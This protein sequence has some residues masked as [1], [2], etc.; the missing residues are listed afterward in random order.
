MGYLENQFYP[1]V[2]QALADQL[3]KAGYRIL[4]FTAP[5]GAADPVLEDVLRY[6]AEAVVLASAHLS[7]ALVEEC[8]I[9]RVP[10]VLINRK[11][12]NAA[13]SSVT[14][15]NIRGARAIAAFL[16]AGGHRRV[17]YMA[18]LEDASTS[19]DRERGFFGY[20]ADCQM[21]PPA[22]AVGSY[23]FEGAMAAARDLLTRD[24]RPDAIF[25]A[26][27]HMAL[28]ALEVARHEFNLAIPRDISIVGFDDAEPARWPSF[29]L[30]TYSQ[31][32]KPMVEE[33]VRILLRLIGDP[34]AGRAN[35]VVPGELIVRGSA[36]RPAAGITR[37]DG[38][39][40]WKEA[41]WNSQGGPLRQAPV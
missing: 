8:R 10:V 14:G 24:P 23:S 28:A 38:R 27:D 32:V 18:G 3:G 30:T 17:A 19:R 33:A 41:D 36:R 29:D 22:R 2:L 25:C 35:A 11:T 21:P 7:S 1:A 39:E 15:D 37:V 26:N 20:F 12:R 40:V 34:S 4:A 13:V 31:P 5:D 16:V 9:A 6:H